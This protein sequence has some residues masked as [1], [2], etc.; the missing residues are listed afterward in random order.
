[1]SSMPVPDTRPRIAVACGVLVDAGG[2]VLLAQRP[3]GKIAAGYWE[4][5]GG[6]IEPEETPRQALDRELH[7]ELGVTVRAARPLIRFRHEYSNRSV[8]LDTWLVTAFDGEPHGREDQA[9]RWLR[10]AE[11]PGQTPQ[12]PTVAPITRA[13]QLPADYVFTPPA[14]SAAELF[15]GLD[16]LPPGALLRLRRPALDDRQYEELARALQ[17]EAAP[18]GLRLVLDRSP[19]QALRLGAAGWHARAEVLAGLAARPPLAQ[20]LC[21]ASC[22]SALE[23]QQAAAL[24]F[25][26]AVLGPVQATAT[27]PE[28]APLGWARFTELSSGVG[29]PVYALGGVGPAQRDAAFAA[30]AQGTAGISAYW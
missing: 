17:R 23:L 29:L 14:V 13:L 22:H 5:P 21:F 9:L 7:E 3:D 25:D 27:H 24:G 4:F 12:L 30:Y 26:A 20:L 8:L 11:L 6:K 18:R 19:E 10:P 15:K 28:A 16:R 2:R 1:M